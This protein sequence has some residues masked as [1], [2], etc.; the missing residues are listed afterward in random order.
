ESELRR[1]ADAVQAD[2]DQRQG[3]LDEAT[4][5]LNAEKAH[6]AE[7]QAELDRALAELERLLVEIYKSSEPDTLGVVLN[8]SSWDDLLTQTEYLDRIQNYDEAVIERVTD[9]RAE[10]EST[11]AS[12]QDIQQ[13]IKV[14]RDEV[15]ARRAEL[16]QAQAEIDAQHSQLA[17]AR[18]ERQAS[19][20]ALQAREKTLEDDLGTSIPN[21][22]ER[23]TLG[24]DGD[25]IP[26]PGAPLA[27][28]A[29]IEAA[30]QINHLPY[31]W[32]G[33]HGSFDDSGYDCSGAVS[34]M[35]HG[36]GMID[37]PLDSGGLTAWGSPGA[38]NWI[39]VYANF[40][41]TFAHVAGLRWD[42]GGNGGGSGPRWHS[43]LRSPAGFIV[44]HPDGF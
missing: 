35:L 12:L 31:V 6:L 44:R 11:V 15:A 16:A 18:Q 13:R 41:H 14:A 10:V 27:V 37:S 8:S 42:T 17:A 1:K 2:L 9:L 7:V 23:A 32:G 30:N 19:L 36:G 22:G 5:S 38:G 4:A 40:G 43:D 29:A 39:T 20:E 3:E 26:P 21:P 25:A 28:K 24:A 33:G 34:F